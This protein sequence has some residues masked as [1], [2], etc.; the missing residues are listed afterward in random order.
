MIE[1]WSFWNY[2]WWLGYKNNYC[3]LNGPLKTS[4]IVTSLVVG[5]VVHIYPKKIKFDFN[6]KTYFIPYKYTFPLDI[7]IHHIPVLSL[8]DNSNTNPLCG[9][10]LLLPCSLYSLLNYYRNINLKEVYGINLFKIYGSSF[11]ITSIYGINYHFCKKQKQ[12]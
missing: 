3:H 5:F 7:I 4:L 12:K 10:Y 6:N 11:I 8:L 9:A 1:Y 2:I